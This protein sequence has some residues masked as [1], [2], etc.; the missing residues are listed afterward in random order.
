MVESFLQGLV[1]GR[2]LDS[3]VQKEIISIQTHAAVGQGIG[4]AINVNYEQ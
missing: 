1:V 2:G 3:P 4:K